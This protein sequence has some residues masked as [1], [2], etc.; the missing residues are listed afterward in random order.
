MHM[1]VHLI[2]MR[3]CACTHTHTNDVPSLKCSGDL[4]SIPQHFIKTPCALPRLS[5]GLSFFPFF[6]PRQGGHWEAGD[7]ERVNQKPSMSMKTFVCVRKDKKPHAAAACA[8]VSDNGSTTKETRSPCFTE[9]E[10]NA[11]VS[12]LCVLLLCLTPDP[13]STLFW[14]QHHT[15]E[16]A[17]GEIRALVRRA[18]HCLYRLAVAQ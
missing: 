2:C 11:K 16:A 1:Q 7:R 12:T 14:P 17:M 8:A 4:H 13:S 18:Q 9:Q 3:M 15:D 5:I 10:E 6:I